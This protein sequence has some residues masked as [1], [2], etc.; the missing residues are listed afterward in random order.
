MCCALAGEATRATE[1]LCR[2]GLFVQTRLAANSEKIEMSA[3]ESEVFSVFKTQGQPTVTYVHREGG[4]YEEKLTQ[5]INRKGTVC[6]LTGPSKTGKTTLYMKVAQ[7]NGITPVQVRCHN[8][9]SAQEFWQ[10]ALEKIGLERTAES[11]ES[12]GSSVGAGG[13]VSGEF[14]FKPIA[15]LQG[16]TSMAV[17]EESSQTDVRQRVLAS[18]SP[19]HLIPLLQNSKLLLVVEDFHYLTPPV[20]QNV[21]QQWK[22]FV[23]NEVPVLVVGTTHHAADLAYSNRDL[24]GRTVQ[25]DLSTWKQADLAKIASQGFAFLEM[26][27]GVDIV[28]VIAKESVGVPI[29]TQSACLHLLLGRRSL[30]PSEKAPLSRRDAYDA[31]HATAVEEYRFFEQV[32]DRLV[33]GPRKRA[34]KYNTYELLLAA[35]A[36]DPIAFA[37]KRE[38]ML[39]R[40]RDNVQQELVPPA[41]SVSSTLNALQTFQR[42]LGIEL[43]EWS[44]R[45]QCLYILEPIFLFYLR[46]REKRETPLTWKQLLKGIASMGALIESMKLSIPRPN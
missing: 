29:I 38:E 15:S 8:Q 24:L 2:R 46:W 1:D 11:H 13:E 36:L 45:D 12:T 44:H 16:K 25:I 21:F 18:P 28:E 40:I 34:R 22:T 27:V 10:I 5:V 6:V 14:G 33:R 30:A 23:D 26:N 31:L 41:A 35:F 42:R 37:L 17:T 20:Q 32:Y 19:D 39:A 9:L 7:D 43:L 3:L 4:I